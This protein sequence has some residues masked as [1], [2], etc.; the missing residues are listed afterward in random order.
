MISGRLISDIEYSTRQCI[1]L[2]DTISY[3]RLNGDFNNMYI[4]NRMDMREAFG[5][6]FKEFWETQ[7]SNVL[8]SDKETIIAN[9]EHVLSGVLEEA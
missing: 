8:I 4:I 5:K 7:D 3:L 2:S 1:F 6:M 9:I